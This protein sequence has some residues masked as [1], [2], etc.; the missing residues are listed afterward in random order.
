MQLIPTVARA[1]LSRSEFRYSNEIDMAPALSPKTVT[2]FH[3]R[4]RVV[5]LQQVQRTLFGSPPKEAILDWIQRS[6]RI[7]SFSPRLRA[8][9]E[10]ASVPCGNPNGPSR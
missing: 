10:A 4:R 8:P 2:Y 9:R 3:V 1:S 6:A 7:W 5:L